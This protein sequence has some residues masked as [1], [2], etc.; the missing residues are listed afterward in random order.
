MV[1]QVESFLVVFIMMSTLVANLIKS[2]I[3]QL[4]LSDQFC[5]GLPQVINEIFSIPK[6]L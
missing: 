3:T 1:I 6:Q 5:V 2:W 4:I